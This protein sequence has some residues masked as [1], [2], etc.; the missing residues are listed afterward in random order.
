V[1]YSVDWIDE[2]RRILAVRLYDPLTAEDT[3]ALQ[4]KLTPIVEAG[5]PLFILAD[6]TEVDVMK[7]YSGLGA[8]FEGLA[9]PN[10]SEQQWRHSRMAIIGGGMLVNTVLSFVQGSDDEPQLIRTFKHEDKAFAWLDE[11][12]RANFDPPS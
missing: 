1:P 11:A 7:A 10:V 9:V 6:I 12:S 8:A 5:A 3:D 4:S 2:D